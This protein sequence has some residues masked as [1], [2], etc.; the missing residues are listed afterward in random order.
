MPDLTDIE[1][2]ERET[3]YIVCNQSHFYKVGKNEG[4]ILV[5]LKNGVCINEVSQ[6]LGLSINELLN[7]LKSF[8]DRGMI[9][10]QEDLHLLY[11]RFPLLSPDHILGRIAD[12]IRRSKTFFCFLLF[13]ANY[14]ITLGIT[15]LILSHREIFK[16][17]IFQLNIYEILY[18]MLILFITLGIR[19]LCH[20]LAYKYF[21]GYVGKLGI[22]FVFFLPVIYCDIRGNRTQMTKVQKAITAFAGI[23]CNTILLSISSILFFIGIRSSYL[24]ILLYINLITICVNL[25]PFIPFDG[26]HVLDTVFGIPDLYKK[27]FIGVSNVFRH[28]SREE[29]II[30]FY[31]IANWIFII[32]SLYVGVISISGILT[33]I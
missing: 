25:I 16:Y 30:G 11:F 24:I 1:L 7:L 28:C 8:E 19:E 31:G 27:S 23:Y 4:S 21:G 15:M 5:R 14:V 29:K 6:Q 13:I 9:Q 26:Y 12:T 33:K 18:S 10:P 20:G 22:L 3:Y 2:I 32:V 17:N